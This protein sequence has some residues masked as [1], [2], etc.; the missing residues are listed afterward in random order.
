MFHLDGENGIKAWAE[1]PY[2]YSF[3]GETH[4]PWKFPLAPSHTV[5]FPKRSGGKG[6][7]PR[8]P[9]FQEAVLRLALLRLQRAA[10]QSSDRGNGV[11]SGSGG[12]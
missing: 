2:Y 3:T 4:D 6:L 7:A 8:L 11:R 5:W 10:V 12:R 9:G 1:N